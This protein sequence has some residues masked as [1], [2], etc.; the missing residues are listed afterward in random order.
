M[1]KKKQKQLKGQDLIRSIEEQHMKPTVPA[2]R[3]GDTVDV[4]VRIRE[5]GKE[6]TQVFTGTCIARKGGGNRETFTVRRIVQGEGVER[7]FP[8]HSPNIQS[9]E[10]RR[11]GRVRRAKLHYLR[12]RTGRASRVQEDLR[13]RKED[14]EE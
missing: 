14:A 1:A 8:L 11:R 3:V 4:A 9:I 13:V 10:V 5:A 7:V 12:Q 2:F 6:R